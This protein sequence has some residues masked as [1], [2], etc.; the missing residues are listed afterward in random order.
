MLLI[1]EEDYEQTDCSKAGSFQ[2]WKI[3]SFKRADAI[4]PLDKVELADLGGP[5]D[6]V[7]P[8]D[9]F[10][11]A[12]WFDYHQSGIAAVAY[13]GGGVRLVD[14]RDPKNIKPYGYAVGGETWDA[15]WMP[16]RRTDDTAKLPRTNILYQVDL[17]TG[18]TVY[19]VNLPGPATQTQ[20]TAAGVT[21]TSFSTGVTP[22]MNHTCSEQMAIDL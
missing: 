10:C 20:A 18:L 21:Q 22:R 2:T 13:Y 7:L 6:F 12:H 4:K 11:S 15:Y 17:V 3:N 1:T 19:R 16:Q 14:V 5:A 8:E 9:A